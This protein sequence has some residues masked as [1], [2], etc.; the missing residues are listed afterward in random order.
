[1]Q[2]HL[3]ATPGGGHSLGRMARG[4]PVQVGP[5]I[6]GFSA[7]TEA[8][9]GCKRPL[10]SWAS[11]ADFMLMIPEWAWL[12][13]LWRSSEADALHLFPLDTRGEGQ[14]PSVWSQPA[15]GPD[16]YAE[17]G[18]ARGGAHVLVRPLKVPTTPALQKQGDEMKFQLALALFF[19]FPVPRG[20]IPPY[21]TH[22][23]CERQSV[24]VNW[25]QASQ[26]PREDWKAKAFSGSFGAD[27]S[28][29]K[30]PHPC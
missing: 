12:G 7:S 3:T 19:F 29:S 1:M 26:P 25:R 4:W 18:G 9:H 6:T 16:P 22:S 24:S 28:I 17:G 14:L 20:L 11:W 30:V 27:F 2:K 10:T 8:W 23:L 13:W 5:W 21:V 15:T